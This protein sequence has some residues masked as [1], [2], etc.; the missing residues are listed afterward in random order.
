MFDN[1]TNPA[2]GEIIKIAKGNS[3]A[4]YDLYTGLYTRY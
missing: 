1:M 3:P 2:N 4:S